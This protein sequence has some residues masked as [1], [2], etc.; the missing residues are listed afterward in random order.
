MIEGV[1]HSMLNLSAVTDVV[2]SRIALAQLPQGSEYPAI[3]YNIT[4]NAPHRQTYCKPTQTA[5]VRVQ[6]NP[7]APSFGLVNELHAK[8]KE[9]MECVDVIKGGHK[10]LSCRYENTSR[11]DKDDFSGMWT[12]AADYIL[13]VEMQPTGA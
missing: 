4:S 9:V 5:R 6:I 12:S 11:A 8:I 1:I 13:L 3:V 2:G 10:V 7:L